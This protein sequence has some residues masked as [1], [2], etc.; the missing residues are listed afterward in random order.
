M[1]DIGEL[2]TITRGVW[3]TA[4]LMRRRSVLRRLGS[5]AAIL[6]S[7]SLRALAQPAG[8]PG[9]ESKTLEL[10]AATVLPAELGDA[11]VKKAAN[12]FVRWVANYRAGAETEH[13]YG[14]TRIRAKS[15]SPAPLYPSRGIDAY[16][17]TQ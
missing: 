16:A 11:G 6:K 17:A 13:G 2:L 10:L 7:Q 3:H 1:Q 14:V 12:D 4:G 9:A 5:F 15:A 8:F